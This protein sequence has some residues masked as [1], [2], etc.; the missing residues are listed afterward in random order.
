M[1][2][3]LSLIII[4]TFQFSSIFGG[5]WTCQRFKLL[6]ETKTDTI[7]GFVEFGDNFRNYDDNE[8]IKFMNENY[9]YPH[10]TITVY[11][12]IYNLNYPTM[13]DY[14]LTAIL[15]Q[16]VS[17]IAIDKIENIK[18]IYK[19]PCQE[20]TKKR[21]INNYEYFY[22]WIGHTMPISELTFQEIELLKGEPKYSSS[23]GDP[24]SEYSGYYIL[25]YADNVLKEEIDKIVNKY[26]EAILNYSGDKPKYIFLDETY[27]NLKNDLRKKQIIIFRID[28]VA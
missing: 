25:S 10:D 23:Y 20:W 16:D 4:L 19:S 28:Y 2:N 7:I 26:K 15:R 11:D 18:F 17:K 6:I 3:H 13:R 9:K 21:D 5:G 24:L 1:K 12:T 8:I 27:S 22:A 14:K